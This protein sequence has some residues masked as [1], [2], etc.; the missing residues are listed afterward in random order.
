MVTE[1]VI[2]HPCHNAAALSIAAAAAGGLQTV[3]LTELGWL[4][5]LSGIAVANAVYY[6]SLRS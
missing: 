4:L 1:L 6:Q 2:K 3:Y 5:L